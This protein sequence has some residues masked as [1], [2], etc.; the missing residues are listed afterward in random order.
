MDTSI[1]KQP[2]D[3]GINYYC[4]KVFKSFCEQEEIYVYADNINVTDD[5]SIH[6]ITYSEDGE[7]EEVTLVIPANQWKCCYLADEKYGTPKSIHR[8]KKEFGKYFPPE[9]EPVVK[10]ENKTGPEEDEEVEEETEETE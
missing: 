10:E 4:V 8:W 6:F 7:E 9:P 3:W 2:E 5:G 1:F